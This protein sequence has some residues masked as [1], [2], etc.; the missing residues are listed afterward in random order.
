MPQSFIFRM[1]A[2]DFRR[3]IAEAPMDIDSEIK[4]NLTPEECQRLSRVKSSLHKYNDF[5]DILP[6]D[7]MDAMIEGVRK[8]AL[9]K[10][11]SETVKHVRGLKEATTAQDQMAIVFMA[12]FHDEPEVRRGR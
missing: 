4:G 8:I 6:Q 11:V 7:E 1:V 3:V 2:M 12:F 9:T 10:T 5:H